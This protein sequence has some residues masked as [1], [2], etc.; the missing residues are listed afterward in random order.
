[1]AVSP[2]TTRQDGAKAG[3]TV[4]RDDVLAN[5]SRLRGD[6]ESLIGTVQGG[7]STLAQIFDDENSHDAN[8][9]YGAVY[10]VKLA[11]SIP[12]IGKVRARRVLAEHGLG[13][14]TRV[15]EVDA[16]TRAALVKALV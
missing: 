5:I 12:G 3:A 11:E 8:R 1:M 4:H 16:T 15:C 2:T 13:E 7:T 14:R 9:P 10:L 6:L